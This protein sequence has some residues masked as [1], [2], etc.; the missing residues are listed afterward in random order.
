M[1]GLLRGVLDQNEPTLICWCL[2]APFEVPDDTQNTFWFWLES[3]M[4]GLLRG[5]LDK[6]EPTLTMLVLLVPIGGAGLHSEHIL[7]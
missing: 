4:I 5:V 7:D 1:I 3:C 2:L 6:D